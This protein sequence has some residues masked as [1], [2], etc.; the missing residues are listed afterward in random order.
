MHIPFY[1]EI[2][3]LDNPMFC[4]ISFY[5]SVFLIKLKK[6][7]F[8]LSQTVPYLSYPVL[9]TLAFLSS[10]IKKLPLGPR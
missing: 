4:L 5:F 2:T 6:F 7:F 9:E 1:K 3:S 8:P 10:F